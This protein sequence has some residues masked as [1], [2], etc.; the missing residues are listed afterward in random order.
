MEDE[1][2]LVPM[3]SIRPVLEALRESIEKLELNGEAVCEKC[4]GTGNELVSTER[5]TAS[6]A[7]SNGCRG[8]FTLEVNK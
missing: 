4:N 3:T 7:C 1:R 6:R 5:G 8:R 2:P